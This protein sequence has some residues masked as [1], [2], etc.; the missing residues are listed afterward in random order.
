FNMATALGINACINNTSY[1][2]A[3]NDGISSADLLSRTAGTLDKEKVPSMVK[4]YKTEDGEGVGV[5]FIVSTFNKT[6][7]MAEFYVTFFNMK[8]KEVLHSERISGKPVG[9]GL[10]N[11]WAGSVTNVLKSIEKDYSKAWLKRFQ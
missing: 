3:A 7:E 5:V 8:T 9:F 10:R 4:D 11:F 6:Q 1:V 2:Q